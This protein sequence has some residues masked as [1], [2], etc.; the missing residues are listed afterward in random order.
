MSAKTVL[1]GKTP[2]EVLMGGAAQM[3]LIAGPCVMQDEIQ[4]YE[5]ASRLKEYT[6]IIGIPFI[7]KASFDKANRTSINSFRGVGIEKGLSILEQIKYNL[8]VCVLSDVHRV[9]DMQRAA[10]VLDVIQIPAFLCRQ[11]DLLIAAAETGKPINV[12]KGQFLAPWGMGRVIEKI[13]ESENT[14]IMLTERGTCF[15]YNELVVD[16]RGLDTMRRYGYPIIF[17]ASHSTQ[18]PGALDSMSGGEPEFIFPL[19]RAAVAVGVDGVFIEVHQDPQKA[20]C[21]ASTSLALADVPK[22]LEQLVAI[23]KSLGVSYA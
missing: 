12:K 16:F 2:N 8:D 19:A 23:K 9:E 5:I 11:T 3:V 13:T 20:K 14:K 15:G 7:F 1:V 18:Q 6:D 21:D 17:D 4:T 10:E 22:L